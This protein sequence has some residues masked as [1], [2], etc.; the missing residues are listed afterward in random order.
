MGGPALG[1]TVRAISVAA[2][3]AALAFCFHTQ[4]DGKDRFLNNIPDHRVLVDGYYYWIM[5]I[6]PDDAPARGIGKH[7][8][9]RVYNERG[10]VMCAAMPT[11]AAAARR[12]HGYESSAVYDPIGEPGKSVDRGGCVNL[13]TPHRSQTKSTHSLAGA[14]ALVQIELWDGKIEHMSE[15]YRRGRAAST[16]ARRRSPG[17]VPAQVART[18]R[19]PA[20]TPIR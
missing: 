5:R 4:S 16:A 14:Q 12:L 18:K 6:N 11:A 13:L 7:D 20:R 19:R 3:H 10:A 15:A 1:R 8:L 17:L 2:D 9:V